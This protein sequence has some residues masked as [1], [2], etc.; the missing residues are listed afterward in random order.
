MALMGAIANILQTKAASCE[1]CYKCVKNCPVKAIKLTESLLEIDTD[2]CICCGRC[3]SSC[4][5]SAISLADDLGAVRELMAGEPTVAVVSPA[6]EAAFRPARRSQLRAALKLLGFYAVEDSVMAEELG[7][8]GYAE[9]P[10]SRAGRSVIRS[11][12]PAVVGLVRRYYP[13]L[14]DFLA[15]IADPAVI[16]SRL[17][18]QL[19]PETPAVVYIGPCTAMKAQIQD[20][21]GHG[22]KHVLT[23]GQLAELLEQS[24]IDPE[25][26][27]GQE[28]L[29]LNLGRSLSVPGGLPADLAGSFADFELVVARNP[30]D[31]RRALDELEAGAKALAFLDLLN[32]GACVDWS[33]TDSCE[34]RSSPANALE[35]TKDGFVLASLGA[36]PPI[37]ISQCF[38]PRPVEKAPFSAAREQEAL[39]AVGLGEPARQLNCLAC[40]YDTCR[41]QARAVLTG[42]SDWTAC[43]LHRKRLFDEAAAALREESNTDGLTGLLN[44]KGFVDRFTGEF[45]RYKRYRSPLSVLMIDV[46]NFKQI[47]DRHGHLAGDSLLKL[48]AQL[49]ASGLRDSD[50]LARY[51]GDEFAVILPGITAEEAVAVAEKLRIR[52]AGASLWLGMDIAERVSLSLGICGAGESDEDIVSL[53]KRADEA[54]YEAKRAGRNQA[55]VKN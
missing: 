38:S 8:A 7:A 41:E 40:G 55:V 51:G 9:L 13:A 26:L 24:H 54:L 14:V 5:R 6:V 47:N 48:I 45:A 18:G 53:L 44:Y 11:T 10:A 1:R 34:D 29:D 50:I 16:Q 22:I 46:D 49:L 20:I 3:V 19:Y 4:S 52:V 36:L 35:R 31:V 23:T 15:P 43:F 39:N 17:I 30:E 28:S 2:R 42:H 37:D 21:S 33:S 27:K 12:C 32:C 25:G